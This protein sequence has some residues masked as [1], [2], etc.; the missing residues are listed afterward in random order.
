MTQGTIELMSLRTLRVSPLLRKPLLGLLLAV[1]PVLL[2]FLPTAGTTAVAAPSQASP[3]PVVFEKEI[4]PLLTK[5]CAPCHGAKKVRGG[6]NVEEYADLARVQ[7]DQVTWRSV[8]RQ[9]HERSMPPEGVTQ[10][11][12]AERDKMDAYLTHAL[13][14]VGEGAVPK[15]PGR[16]L[17]HRL[18]RLEYNNTVR[19]LFGVT[20]RPADTFPADGSGGGGFDNNADTLFVPP[21]LM[22]RYL[23][24]AGEILR[25][26]NPDRLFFLKPTKTRTPRQTAAEILRKHATRAYR[27]PLEPGEAERLL[28]LYDRAIKDKETHENAIRFALK[29][30]LIAPSFL[31]RVEQDK[32]AQGSGGAAPLSDYELASRLSYFLWASMPDDTLFELARTKKLRAPGVLEAQIQR[33]LKSPKSKAFADSFAGQWLRVRDLY[34]SVQPDPNLFPDWTPALRDAAYNESIC[35]FQSVLQND[36]SV[37]TLLDSNYTYLNGD[38]AKHYGI[39]G[40]TG[41]EMRRVQ[42]TDRRRGGVLTQASVLTLTSYNRRTSPV[43]RGKWVLEEILGTPPPPPPPSVATLSQDDKP[44]KEGLTFRQRLEQHRSKPECASCHSR[45]DPLGF[46]LENFDVT[47]KWRVKIADAPVDSSGVLTSG[48][49]FSGPIELKAQLLRRKEDF[50]R[51]LSE[52][53]LAYALGRGLEPYDL[54]AVRKITAALEKDDY[55]SGALLAE[56]VKSYPF[57]YRKNGETAVAMEKNLA[58]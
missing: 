3:D 53:M 40:V 31:F 35:L 15:D 43:L 46:G 21:I 45:M 49:K 41:P 9:I 7:K 54:P 51:N 23:E 32:V 57:Q 13:N 26:A 36:E 55:R 19:D 14:N 25:D 56:I 5:Y 34:T 12:Q 28:L 10:P 42:L 29:A 20:S 6:V 58:P 18:S 33:M 47:G 38:L 37:L 2:A 22:E 4:K 50:A 1:P 48:E 27:R 52:K 8:A 24:A 17:I 39:D 16:V 30:V 44:N 11:T